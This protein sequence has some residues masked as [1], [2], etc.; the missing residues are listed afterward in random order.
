MVVARA[1]VVTAFKA[2][3]GLKQQLRFSTSKEDICLQLSSSSSQTAMEHMVLQMLSEQGWRSLHQ[4]MLLSLPLLS[5]PKPFL[6]AL[7][8]MSDACKS[9]SCV[10]PVLQSPS[11]AVRHMW[12]DHGPH[13]FHVHLM[14]S[15]W[16]TTPAGS[17]SGSTCA[18]LPALS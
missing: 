2:L 14:T 11:T 4:N 5:N 13:Q 12:P 7:Y 6:T 1:R 16:H 10:P 18:H 3:I 15:W 8:A 17:R 9:C